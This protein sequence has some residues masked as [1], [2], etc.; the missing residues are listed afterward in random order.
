[1]NYARHYLKLINRARTRVPSGY[2]E[3]HHVW[4]KCLVGPNDDV[5]RLTPEEH[6]VAHQLLTKMLPDHRGLAWA[7]MCM[8]GKS[9]KHGRTNKAYGWV[10][11]RLGAAISRASKGVPKSSAHRL[12]LAEAKRGQ[13]G[14][15][16][17]P[18][19]LETKERIRNTKTTR[20]DADLLVLPASALS[21]SQRLR[22]RELRATQ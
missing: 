22:I 12:A 15:H 20:T 10:R 8:T 7:C 17:T 5:V 19:S 6:Y 9:W 1:M 3:R 21:R 18:H 11:R 14:N 16:T 4:P 13:P 2:S